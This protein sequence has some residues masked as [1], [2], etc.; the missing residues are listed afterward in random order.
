MNMNDYEKSIKRG[1]EELRKKDEAFDGLVSEITTKIEKQIEE[2][3]AEK[4]FNP[5]SSTDY[6]VRIKVKAVPM[7]KEE[8]DYLLNFLRI[9]YSSK[10]AGNH[11]TMRKCL[12]SEQYCVRSESY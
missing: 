2:R 12:L 10:V 1:M 5:K 7:S 6:E 4:S 3:N 8:K 11:F 9:Q